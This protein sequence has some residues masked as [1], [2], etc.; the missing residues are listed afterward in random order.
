[1]Y[2]ISQKVQ[3]VVE[4]F[5]ANVQELLGGKAKAMVVLQ[6]R[7]EAV[8][9]KLAID[10]YI[11]EKGYPLGTL[12][13]FS[14][15][16]VDKESGPEPFTETNQTVNPDLKGQDLKEVFAGEDYQL[17]LV[18]NKFQTGFDQPLL[19]AMYIDRRLAGVQAVQTLSRLNRAYKS[20][21][22]RKDTTYVL[23]F[24]DSSDEVLKAFSQ[25]YGKAELE[26]AT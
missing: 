26:A 11:K 14:G 21:D 8:R 5:R 17:L 18:A 10:K 2:N 19:S 23:D 15:E 7:K 13:A 16:V 22:I 1:P 3:I 12:V 9:W 24:S 20:G 4:H 6:S 25:Y